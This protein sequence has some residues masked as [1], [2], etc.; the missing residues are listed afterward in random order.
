MFPDTNK[1]ANNHLIEEDDIDMLWDVNKELTLVISCIKKALW[2]KNQQN[3]GN[4]CL[5]RELLQKC[6]GGQIIEMLK[7]I[8][9]G[10]EKTALVK[11]ELNSFF[12]NQAQS[13][14]NH[15]K[16][17]SEVIVPKIEIKTEYLDESEKI[18]ISSTDERTAY[19]SDSLSDNHQ[20]VPG[21]V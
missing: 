15:M 12:Q 14:E 18:D 17:K 8:L 4:K 2:S 11:N 5:I 21:E 9:S 1:M 20:E 13:F 10:E 7:N 16:I 6:S 3:F 19:T